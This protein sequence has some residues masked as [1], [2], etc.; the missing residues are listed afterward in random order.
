MDSYVR[1][2]QDGNV[3]Y[4]PIQLQT[5]RG[6][7]NLDNDPIM[8]RILEEVV[9]DDAEKT[10]TERPN[11]PIPRPVIPP[12]PPEPPP[13]TKLTA[14]TDEEIMDAIKDYAEYNLV[15][16]ILI[17]GKSL[18]SEIFYNIRYFLY[19]FFSD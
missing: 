15:S 14:E 13:V 1:P 16:L 18:R 4:H 10:K 11:A 9:A 2:V 6:V 19:L 17:T 3:Q 7:K 5:P 12:A 8:N